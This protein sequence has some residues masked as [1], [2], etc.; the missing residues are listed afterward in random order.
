MKPLTV[1]SHYR[2]LCLRIVPKI[3][4][5]VLLTDFP[6]DLVMNTGDTYKTSSGYQ[7]TGYSANADMTGDVID[8]EGIAGYAGID[9]DVVASGLFDGAR[10]YLFA[11]DWR[12]PIVDNE[13][14]TCSIF[15]K[16]A[17][18]DG[19]YRIEEMSLIDL[20]GQSIG[21]TVRPQ[22]RHTFGDKICRV[23]L[24]KYAGI[25]VSATDNANFIVGGRTE[26]DD[27]FGYG[28]I[29]IT[30]GKNVNIKPREIKA[31]TASGNVEV[32]EP[33][34]YPLQAGDT[35]EMTA[36]CRKRLSDCRDKWNNVINFGGF[37][38]VPTSTTYASVG[39]K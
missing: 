33:F 13:P 14:M 16:T 20:L 5:P 12:N 24:T 2:A 17:L 27:Y 29:A 1:D 36:G 35:Y 15:G 31:Y 9:R 28:T 22:C 23:P 21:M 8:L 19:R 25:I 7:F 30:S 39:R 6:R 37:P 3:I 26:P 18:V 38:N 10:C 11:V 34:Y 4:P 32:Y